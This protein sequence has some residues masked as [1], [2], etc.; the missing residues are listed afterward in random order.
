M[1]NLVAAVVWLRRGALADITAWDAVE[2]A[3]SH[4]LQIVTHG[5]SRD[6]FRSVLAVAVQLNAESQFNSHAA[7][8]R[9]WLEAT[10]SIFNEAAPWA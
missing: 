8:V 7:A 3:L 5:R 1:T 9:S 10:G 2:Q 6:Q 4:R